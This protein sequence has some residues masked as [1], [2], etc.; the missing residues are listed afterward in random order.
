MLGE[1]LRIVFYLG[2][3]PLLIAIVGSVIVAASLVHILG[4][5][6]PVR[7]TCGRVVL[8]CGILWL[9]AAAYEEYCRRWSEANLEN[10]PIRVDLLLVP[11]FLLLVAIVAI[12]VWTIGLSR[13]KREGHRPTTN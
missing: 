12:V 5:R 11:P 1:L 4:K 3:R 13:S 6:S 2:E 7:K 9:G 8:S 10:V